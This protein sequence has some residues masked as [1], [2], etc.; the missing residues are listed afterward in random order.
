MRVYPAI[1]PPPPIAERITAFSN[2][3]ADPASG[4]TAQRASGPHITLRAPQYPTDFNAWLAVTTAA[5]GN[6]S[7]HNFTVEAG[8]PAFINRHVLALNI[9]APELL[10]LNAILA[11][12][13]APYNHPGITNYD[14]D[15]Y[16]PHITLAYCKSL[17]HQQRVALYQRV[18]S[19]LL[20]LR[21]FTAS[22]VAVFTRNELDFEYRLSHKLP[23]N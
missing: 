11:T 12:A 14:Y 16:R 23:L 1:M 9:S 17:T 18:K 2:S 7:V 22:S 3:I 20:P 10:K 21:A 15:L 4:I 19:E 5:L 13:L 8:E 6:S